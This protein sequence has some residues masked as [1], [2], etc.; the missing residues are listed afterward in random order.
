MQC[1]AIGCN[2]NGLCEDEEG[3]TLEGNG[4]KGRIGGIGDDQETMEQRNRTEQGAHEQTEQ[5]V[6]K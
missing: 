6:H 1:E 4:G 5:T 3:M 2:W